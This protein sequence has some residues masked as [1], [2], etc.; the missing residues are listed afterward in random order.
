M[1]L[2]TWTVQRPPYI[3]SYR[4]AWFWGT[5]GLYSCREMERRKSR[6]HL[7]GRWLTLLPLALL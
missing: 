6:E 4:G 3:S 7:E 5:L 2:S 1:C